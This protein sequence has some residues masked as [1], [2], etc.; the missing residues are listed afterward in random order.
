MMFKV[1]DGDGFIFD[2]EFD[3]EADVTRFALRTQENL[4]V[5]DRARSVRTWDG[6]T[7]IWRSN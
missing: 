3:D 7:T 4:Y 6:R 1:E 2:L 5:G